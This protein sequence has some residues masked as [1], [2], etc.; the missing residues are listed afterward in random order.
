MANHEIMNEA[1]TRGAD[2]A[3]VTGVVE[4]VIAHAM[5]ERGAAIDA[6]AVERAVRLCLESAEREVIV[7]E[8]EG[9]IAGYVAVHW[10]PFPML[11]GTEAYIS[12]L[13]VDRA[14][15]GAGLGSRLIAEVE[16]RARERGCARLMLNNRMAADSFTRGFYAKLGFRHRDDFANMV[17]RV[18]TE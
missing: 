13:I 2:A 12:D 8:R 15:R 18:G 3:D 10:I 16:R 14:M 9:R 11:A 4:L 5:D 7:A 1:R 17:K 6:D